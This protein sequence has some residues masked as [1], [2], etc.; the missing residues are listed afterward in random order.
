MPETTIEN[1]S[2]CK[3]QFDINTGYR[4]AEAKQY[5][6]SKCYICSR[7]GRECSLAEIR[8]CLD[9]GRRLVQHARCLVI[10]SK[11]L[12]TEIELMNMARLLFHPD[13]EL[14]R[15]TNRQRIATTYNQV[16]GMIP[17][18][19]QLLILDQAT[20][21]AAAAS[22]ALGKNKRVLEEQANEREQKKFKQ[23]ESVR[24]SNGISK[25]DSLMVKKHES[26]L[27]KQ[28]KT[29][30]QLG[31]TREQALEQVNKVKSTK[32]DMLK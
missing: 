1:C 30:M 8:Y 32:G 19:L 10:D 16:V 5:V 31:L 3:E 6:C 7:C 24:K 2:Y 22:L 29:F 14:S 26:M 28:I 25:H 4:D 11:E 9:N 18:D 15:E 20:A 12:D 17:H 21:L 27:E 23:A 13:P